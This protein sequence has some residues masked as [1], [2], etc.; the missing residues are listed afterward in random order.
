MSFLFDSAPDQNKTQEMC[1]MAISE[2]LF[3]FVYCPDK[4]ETQRM[5]DEAIDD[6]LTAL[7]FILNRFVTSK[8]RKKILLLYTQMIICP[9]SKEDFG[10]VIFSC[11]EMGIVSIDLNNLNLDNT[12]NNE[13]NSETIYYSCQTFSLAY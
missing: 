9:I 11:N 1:D 5:C 3:M 6:S 12:N 10:D 4:Y 8:I 13:D 7:K 2:D